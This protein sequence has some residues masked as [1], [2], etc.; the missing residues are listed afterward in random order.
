MGKS[1]IYFKQAAQMSLLFGTFSIIFKCVRRTRL[2]RLKRPL[3]RQAIIFHEM[4]TMTLST[5]NHKYFTIK[6]SFHVYYISRFMCTQRHFIFHSSCLTSLK[7]NFFND[8]PYSQQFWTTAFAIVSNLSI[9]FISF[10]SNHVHH[11]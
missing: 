1:N 4:P 3:N 5:E 6:M 11:I 9:W 7:G 10:Q 2:H 8:R